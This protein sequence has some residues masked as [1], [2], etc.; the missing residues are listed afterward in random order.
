M[1]RSAPDHYVQ[2]LLAELLDGELNDAQQQELLSLVQSDEEV[3]LWVHALVADHALMQ[4]L[5]T[6]ESPEY[7]VRWVLLHTQYQ[8]DGIKFTER[9]TQAALEKAPHAPVEQQ[10]HPQDVQ[11]IKAIAEEQLRKYMAEQERERRLESAARLRNARTAWN[12][13]QLINKAGRIILTSAR[14]TVGT[15]VAA[16]ILLLLIVGIQFHRS[17]RVVAT[18]GETVDSQWVEAPQSA[19]LRPGWLHLDEGYAQLLFTSGAQVLVEGPCALRLDGP[20]AMY[21]EGGSA[22]FQ[23]PPEAVGFIVTTPSSLVKD[24]GTEFGVAV[25]ETRSS[26]IHVFKGSVGVRSQSDRHAP[27]QHLKRGQAA[28][29]KLTGS[30][31]LGRISSSGKRFVRRL[32]ELQEPLPETRYLS[33]ADI[34]GDGNGYGTGQLDWGINVHTGEQAAFDEL[35]R[36]KVQNQA[37]FRPVSWND[38]VDGVFIPGLYDSPLPISHTGIHFDD[39][40][41][42]SGKCF[43]AICNGAKYGIS[44]DRIAPGMLQGQA[45]GTPEYPA[46]RM[47]TNAGITFDLEAI[48]KVNPGLQISRFGAYCGITE[49]SDNYTKAEFWVLVDGQAVFRKF[50]TKTKTKKPVPVNIDVVLDSN[51]RFL[52]LATTDNKKGAHSNWCLFAEP[53]LELVADNDTKK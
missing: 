4:I 36:E 52:T 46:I 18:L 30:V 14:A 39:W 23:V 37:Y 51:A 10:P 40:P 22:S 5:P 8:V 31:V 26:E 28:L 35:Y 33:L 3:A 25:D 17:H 27:L 9:V 43:N 45:V 21:L 50:Y 42:T 19:Q 6:L 24:Y 38:F 53:A 1:S 2:T 44:R 34:V 11:R 7:F 41:K 20:K 49:T 29:A 48:R 47:H 32:S 12:P 15:A 16:G 13:R